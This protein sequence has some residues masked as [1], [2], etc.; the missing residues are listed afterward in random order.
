MRLPDGP[1]APPLWQLMA[2]ITQPTAFLDSAVRRYGDPF[3][4]DWGRLGKRVFVGDPQ[5]IEQIFTAGVTTFDSG[6]AA[7]VLTPVLGSHS[8]LL[9]DG[10]AHQRHRQLLMPPLH[11]ERMRSYGSLIQQITQ[12]MTATWR[13]GQTFWAR[14][15]MQAVSLQVILQ[16]VFGLHPG[17]RCLRLEKSLLKL[18]DLVVTPI[19]RLMI[20][21]PA[22]QQDWGAFSPQGYFVRIRQQVDDLIYE[23]IAE[24]QTRDPDAPT[25]N[26]ILSLLMAARDEEGDPL[27]PQE[28][29]DELI[30]MLIAGHETTATSLTWALYWMH[31]LPDVQARLLTE[32]TTLEDPCDAMAMTR[33]PYLSAIC[34]ETLRLYPVLLT[35]L[36]RITQHPFSIGEYDVPPETRLMPCIYL[37]H[38][39][40]DL[41]P[42][43]EQ[44]HPERF[45]ERQFSPYEYLPFGGGNRRCI[46]AA[47]ALF[48]MKIVLVT[49]L[50]RWH[51]HLLESYPVGYVRRSITMAPASGIKMQVMAPLA[52]SRSEQPSLVVR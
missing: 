20:F 6:R 28:L 13:Q 32:L 40:P 51:L 7:G 5:A 45:I 43:P 29:R 41:Y 22:L 1:Q 15:F 49:L 31:A 48:E 8:L 50:S 12:Q 25:G 30:T 2:W 35:A 3:T 21:F 47:F 10:E 46:G 16:A 24:R 34:A 11:G 39:R 26:D 52:P 38:R 42:E 14:D 33:L 37:T 9:L 4:A 23:E 18:M 19:G 36:P 17:E 44:F 27:T